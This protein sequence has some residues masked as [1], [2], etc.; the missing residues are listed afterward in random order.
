MSCSSF[1]RRCL[2]LVCLA[3]AL[4]G[5]S[6][7]PNVRKQK[8][9]E[10]GQRYFEKGRY[11]E[12]VIQFRN[13]TGVDGMYI[14][15]HYQLAQS[16]MKVQDWQHAYLELSRTVELQPDHY[17]AKADLAN[18]LIATS[19]SSS[20][21]VNLEQLKTVQGYADSLLEKRPN[22]PES[23]IVAANLSGVQQKYDQA[24][25]ETKKAI[26]L[27]PDHGDYY[28]DLALLQTQTNQF[29]A[30]E[31]NYKKAIELKASGANPHMAL[32]AFYQARARYPEA[33]QE[34]RD[35]LVTDPKN[36]DYL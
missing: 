34:V 20:G 3:A 26:S 24:L 5:C 15:A 6:R 10:S 16:Y 8:Y 14:D 4:T 12:A 29:D 11:K 21:S 9:F 25:T 32:A 18:L 27:A 30:A 36:V 1:F 13:A 7:D 28:L 35:L 2:V 22:D 17:K 31:I 23:H 33:E 19:R